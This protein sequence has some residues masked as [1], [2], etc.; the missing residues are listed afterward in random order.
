VPA[1]GRHPEI[2][3]RSVLKGPSPARGTT[4]FLHARIQRKSLEMV[5]A[6]R[7]KALT[8]HLEC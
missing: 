1:A 4:V 5:G 6:V 8:G 7:G 3:R 2:Q